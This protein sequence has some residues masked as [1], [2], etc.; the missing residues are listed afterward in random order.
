[1]NK[2]EIFKS[3]A[4]ITGTVDVLNWG[5]EVN[6]RELSAS[7]METMRKVEGSELEMAAVAIIHG[8]MDADGKKM[9]APNDK[10][11]LMDMSAGDLAKVSAAIIELSDLG[12]DSEK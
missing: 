1:M 10:D 5:G 12:S 3:Y 7:A 2:Q 8:V 11:K 4:L 6:I 9:F